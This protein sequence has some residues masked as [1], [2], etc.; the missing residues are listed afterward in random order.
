MMLYEEGKFLLEDP[1]SKYL[2]EFKNLKVLVKP[3]EGERYTIPATKEITIRDLLRHTSGMTYNWNDDLG[4]LTRRPT[5]PAGCCNMTARSA[6][7]PN[8]SQDCRCSSIPASAW[9][10][11]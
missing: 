7:A 11:A 9:N 3:A 2:P 8:V 4:P 6:T 5:S 1:V 10:T